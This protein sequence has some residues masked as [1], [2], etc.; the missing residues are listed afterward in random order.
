MAAPNGFDVIVVGAG[1]AAL[2]SAVSAEEQGARVCVLEKAPKT[3]R[4]G[5]SMLTGEMRFTFSKLE[6]L[7]ELMRPDVSDGDIEKL[8]QRFI[9]RTDSEL[10]DEI[11][12]VTDDMADR[13]LAEYH[14]RQSY[15][16]VR[17]LRSKGH[18]WIPMIDETTDNPVMMENFGFGLQQRNFA[19]LERQGVDIR[20]STAA[21]SLLQDQRGRV[22][23]VRAMTPDGPE[24]IRA[25]AVI[26]ACGGF[27]ANPEM[28]AAHLGPE[29]GMVKVRGVP[30]NTG[31]G[32]RMALDIG[33]MPGGSWGTCHAA[34]QDLNRP[35]H[36]MPSSQ[37]GFSYADLGR[38]VRYSY[39]FG[40][41]VNIHGRRFV[42]EADDI[43]SRT[44]AK[45]GRAILRQPRGVA[46]QIFDAEARRRGLI[47]PPYGEASGETDSS[48]D[49]LARKLGINGGEL[50][51]TIEEFNAAIAPGDY[52]PNVSVPDGKRTHGIDPP[53]TNF[54]APIAVPPFEGYPVCCGITFTFGGLRVDPKTTQVQHVGGY[55]I[56]N[57][58]AAGEMLGGLWHGNYAGG[59]GMMAGATF[60]RLA[61]ASAA[62][63]AQSG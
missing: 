40:V 30:Y 16:T 41:M 19:H 42:D 22:T 18:H 5:N 43:R 32:L 27:E 23:G 58:Y 45:M 28:R 2:C 61:G 12:R 25:K 20:Y 26:L 35:D 7:V 21:Y 51:Q 13:E 15:P 53:K 38:W 31:D 39:P 6:E 63:A 60:G 62:K 33:A 54:A 49:G 9:P 17:W 14:V 34:P 3:E 59:S 52:N 24:E 48:L 57:L 47:D 29:W 44:Y 8:S 36:S 10:W 11:M 50:I 56:P 37:D 1:N 46:F 4:G 55:A